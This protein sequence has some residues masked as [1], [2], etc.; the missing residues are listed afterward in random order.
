MIKNKKKYLYIWD[1]VNKKI[2]K[3]RMIFYYMEK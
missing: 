2:K 3:I 1:K